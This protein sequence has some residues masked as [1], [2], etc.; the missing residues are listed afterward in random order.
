VRPLR[1]HGR[2]ALVAL[3]A[4]AALVTA[5]CSSSTPSAS[6]PSS[7]PSSSTATS[8]NL[9]GAA[10]A[11]PGDGAS[12]SGGGTSDP[13][14]FTFD[15]TPQIALAGF[16]PPVNGFSF[17]NYTNQEAPSNLT[18]DEMRRFWGD[19]VCASVADG[20]CVLTPPAQQW[21]SQVNDAMNTG[22][23]EGMAA[24]A[25]HFMKGNVN[26]GE[27]G[28]AASANGLQLQG[29]PKLAREI[30]Y[31]FVTQALT[32]FRTTRF[33]TLKPSEV[34][35]KL[36]ESFQPGA[37]ELYTFGFFKRDKTGGHA[38]T[39]YG[40]SDR[41]NG[42]VDVAVYDN[43][44]PNQARVLRIDTTNEKWTYNSAVNPTQPSDLYE[45][46]A[47]TSSLWLSPLSTRLQKQDC[48]FCGSTS[49]PAAAPTPPPDAAGG[50]P[51]PAAVPIVGSAA[52]GGGGGGGGATVY[53]QLF[54][55]AAAGDA[56]VD[57]TITDLDG[58]PLPGVKEEPVFAGSGI[59]PTQLIPTGTAFKVK[60]DGTKLT[61]PIV[62]DLTLIG[63]NTA[64]YVDGINVDPQQVDTIEFRP[65]EDSI[66]YETTGQ[67]S[68][69]IGAGFADPGADYAVEI[70][71]VDLP[72]GGKVELKMDRAA[73]K[74]TITNNGKAKGTYAVAI[75][76][77]ADT[78]EELFSH[79]GVDLEAGDSLVLDYGQWAKGEQLAAQVVAS[80]SASTLELDNT[81]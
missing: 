64:D 16:S 17:A 23:C 8:S 25:L 50:S 76:R 77:I 61:A 29:N 58:N 80:G 42:Q 14:S 11:T 6:A 59:P 79:D 40:L 1:A 47:S 34:V 20:T 26:L 55:S 4:S 22:H 28:Q 13:S 52:S 66:T 62:T 67:E 69:N 44:F 71:G 33:E 60:L 41:G 78:G 74:V 39:P 75:D 43:N 5:A 24:L 65:T 51:D 32:P 45:G 3:L 54:L 63:P 68:P 57:V 49:A 35:A 36:R 19:Q 81:K 56:G 31:W 30:A 73:G 18:A 21:M 48:P 38:I 27:F 10:G 15:G 9:L 72:D 7:A 12:G 2:N 37:S 70:G 46:D 53:D